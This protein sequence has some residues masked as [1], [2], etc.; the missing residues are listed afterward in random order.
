MFLLAIVTATETASFTSNSTIERGLAFVSYQ[1]SIA[2]GFQFLQTV[3]ANQPTFAPSHAPEPGWD[4]I[5]GQAGTGT[6]FMNGYDIQNTNANLQLE[7]EFVVSRGGEYFFSP[8]I[9]AIRDVIS[10]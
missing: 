10:V 5:I 1:S 2:D 6:R 3:W 8:S 9:S 7:Q 4:P